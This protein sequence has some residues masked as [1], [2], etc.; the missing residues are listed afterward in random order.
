M[1]SGFK[2]EC[3]IPGHS[4]SNASITDTYCM[5][6]IADLIIP[7]DPPLLLNKNTINKP[8]VPIRIPMTRNNIDIPGSPHFTQPLELDKR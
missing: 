3:N 4:V 5:K 6:L 2:I 7:P 1:L 8:I